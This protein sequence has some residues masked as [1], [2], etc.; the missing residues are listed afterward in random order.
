MA[1]K[2][3]PLEIC[4]N[5]GS[6]KQPPQA[7]QENSQQD[8]DCAFDLEASSAH[9]PLPERLKGDVINVLRISGVLQGILFSSTQ[10]L[11]LVIITSEIYNNNVIIY[12]SAVQQCL[13]LSRKEEKHC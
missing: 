1:Q 2:K 8:T 6:V 4:F 11:G 3:L 5:A 7:F 12:H 10:L 9:Y 13:I